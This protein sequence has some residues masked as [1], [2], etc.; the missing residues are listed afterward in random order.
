MNPLIDKNGHYIGPRLQCPIRYVMQGSNRSLCIDYDSVKF[1]RIRNTIPLQFAIV[2]SKNYDWLNQWSWCIQ[3]GRHTCYARR[4]S[5]HENGKQVTILM[6]RQ[7]LGFPDGVIDHRNGNGLHNIETN[8]RICSSQE[9]RFNCQ[10]QENTSSKYKGVAWIKNR[11]R[12]L[13]QIRHN[14]K[15]INIGTFDSE[16]EAAKAY[17]Q[18]AKELFGEF[19]HPNFEISSPKT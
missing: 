14:G 12:W 11:N 8:L 10:H 15:Q 3:R 19:A 7:I 13:A 17:D 1:I 4:T 5:R 9:N 16:L 2:D 6:H 18:K